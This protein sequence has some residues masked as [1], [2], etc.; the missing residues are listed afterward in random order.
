MITVFFI[1]K[2]LHPA[3]VSQET[4]VLPHSPAALQNC[5][6]LVFI[7]YHPI[8]DFFLQKPTPITPVL[9]LLFVKPNPRLPVYSSLH[10]RYTQ[11]RN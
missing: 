1:H 10:K 6:A 5:T 9:Y 11:Q 8:L 3:D 7:A 2:Q 4:A